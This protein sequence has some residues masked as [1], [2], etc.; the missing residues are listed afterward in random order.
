MG[1]GNAISVS[2]FSILLKLKQAFNFPN[3]SVINGKLLVFSEGDVGWTEN[4][5]D[6]IELL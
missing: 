5:E 2:D 1:D 6:I 4:G 3:R